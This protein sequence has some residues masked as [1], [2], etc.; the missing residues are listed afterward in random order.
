MY[1]EKNDKINNLD[2]DIQQSIPKKY[3]FYKSYWGGNPADEKWL[4]RVIQDSKIIR[5]LLGKNI[6]F[7]GRGRIEGTIDLGE[8]DNQIT[9]TEQFTGRY[10]TNIVLGPYSKIINVKKVWIGGQL[11][12]DSGVSI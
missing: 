6:E 3:G 4:N 11:G 10:G 5:D 8:G 7:R 2:T 12:S 1:S 9:I